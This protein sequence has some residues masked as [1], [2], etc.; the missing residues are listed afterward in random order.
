MLVID[1]L[2]WVIPGFFGFFAYKRRLKLNFPPVGWPY[3]FTVVIFGLPHYL[4]F[5]LFELL[6]SNAKEL[7]FLVH[8]CT[9]FFSVPSAVLLAEVL[10][11]LQTKLGVPIP[12]PFY[13]S[14]FTWKNKPV[15]ITLENKKVYLGI[16][17]DWT[18][19]LSFT[20]TIRVVPLYSGYRDGYGH[21][22]WTFTYPYKDYLPEENSLPEENRSQSYTGLVISREDIMTFSLWDTSHNYV[23]ASP[24]EDIKLTSSK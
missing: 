12:D 6:L 8:I 22:C 2:I 10:V 1:N 3:L 21:I 24:I 13:N 5:E 11:R 14:C 19:D 17:A 16:L 7:E 23:K 4:I 15:L 9:L 20:P 18:R